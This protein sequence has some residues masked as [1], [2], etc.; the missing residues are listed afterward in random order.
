MTPEEYIE[1]GMLVEYSLGLLDKRAAEQVERD[2]DIYPDLRDELEM[3]QDSLEEYA[4]AHRKHPDKSTKEIIWGRICN[5]ELESKMDLD[6]LPLLDRHADAQAWLSAM[7]PLLPVDRSKPFSR[8][9]TET[10]RVTQ[11]LII[12]PQAIPDE[13]HED[14]YESFIILEGICECQIGDQIIRVEAGGYVEIPL[15]MH[16]DVRVLTDYVVG[17]MQRIAA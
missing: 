8:M 3:I 6:H 13:V 2:L 12:A 5:A 17:V 4:S 1:N 11:V 15:H 10:D 9:L 14:V 16:H 7:T